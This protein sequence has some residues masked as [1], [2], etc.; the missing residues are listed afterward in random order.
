MRLG[1]TIALAV[2]LV[3][4]V[5]PGLG[6][7][8]VVDSVLIVPGGT[9]T[10]AA[11][12]LTDREDFNAVKFEAPVALTSIGEYA[13]L[14]CRRLQSIRLP[15]SVTRLGNG[16]FRECD[17]LREAE[18]PGVGVVPDQCFA[19]CGKL[20]TAKLSRRCH[21]IKREA[22]AYC[23]SLK[24]IDIP[25]GV[26]HVGSNAFAFCESLRRVVL[27]PLVK[28][29]ESYAFAECT[30]LREAVLPGNHN[31]LGELIFT[32]CMNLRRIEV[33]SLQ[34]PTFDCNSTLF[35]PDQ[36]ELY[37]RCELFVPRGAVT[38]YRE[39]PWCWSEFREIKEIR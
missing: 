3:A 12:A 24:A 33:N 32:G 14:G 19:W 9:K 15:K 7:Y 38:A 27:S 16:A 4:A 10:I 35:E 36:A 21:D 23:R 34:P 28:E 30:S 26:T 39:S 5:I 20:E 29:L 37:D 13:F 31:M 17:A 2:A 8:R 25:A 22:F 18:L 6:A 11:Y 1:R